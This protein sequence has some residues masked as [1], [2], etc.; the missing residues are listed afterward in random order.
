MSKFGA[1]VDVFTWAGPNPTFDV[2]P[3]DFERLERIYGTPL[4]ESARENLIEEAENYIR[5]RIAE[6]NS[7]SVADM[8]AELDKVKVAIKGF[9]AFAFGELVPQTDAGHALTSLLS[10]HL[11]N[12]PTTVRASDLLFMDPSNSGW[13]PMRGGERSMAVQQSLR[14]LCD[15]AI[16]LSAAVAKTDE[17]VA[18]LER[19]EGGA[20]WQPGRAFKEWLQ[21]MRSWATEHGYPRGPLNATGEPSRFTLLL[22]EINSMFSSHVR[23]EAEKL[24]DLTELVSSPDALAERIRQVVRTGNKIR[25]GGE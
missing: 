17:S 11:R 9:R 3:S 21:R 22:F 16:G 13:Q 6:L 4:S 12:F 20:G 5:W 10:D 15:V 7:D 18:A 1:R 14:F 23:G 24:R 8:R 19:G 25:D 2:S